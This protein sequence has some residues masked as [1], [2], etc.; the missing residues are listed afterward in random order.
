MPAGTRN[1]SGAPSR[2]LC[3]DHMAEAMRVQPGIEPSLG[4]L[5]AM[6]EEAESA[7]RWGQFVDGSLNGR[8]LASWVGD[9]ADEHG[10][11]LAGAWAFVSQ[12]A[13]N[14]SL[15]ATA[16]SMSSHYTGFGP[17]QPTGPSVDFG[18]ASHVYGSDGRRQP[19]YSREQP[20]FSD[21]GRWE[22]QPWP[23]GIAEPPAAQGRPGWANPFSAPTHQT[24]PSPAG[25][26]PLWAPLWAQP[27][28]SVPPAY[29][30]S[31]SGPQ[32]NPMGGGGYAAR[33]RDGFHGRALHA[34][35]RGKRLDPSFRIL[36]RNRSPP[37]SP[38]GGAGDGRASAR[39]RRRLSGDCATTR[40][41]QQDGGKQDL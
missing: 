9:L 6:S 13:R 36:P 33:N 20:D 21:Q 15:K 5:E 32:P 26:P 19:A 12:H 8:T 4:A 11:T 17:A 25:G 7:N 28:Q 37:R 23:P 34:L 3:G 27:G 16:E 2:R 29:T 41:G 38:P 10:T 31:P 24:G 18:D 1:Q 39:V 35:I 14:P 30:G 40:T 22:R